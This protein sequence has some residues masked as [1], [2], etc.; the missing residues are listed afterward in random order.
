MRFVVVGLF[1]L[2]V[3][4]CDSRKAGDSGSVNLEAYTSKE[5]K[6]QSREQ[7][8][9]YAETEGHIRPAEDIVKAHGERVR[10][11]WAPSVEKTSALT[12]LQAAIGATRPQIATL[13]T[14]GVSEWEALKPGIEAGLKEIDARKEAYEKIE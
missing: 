3:V 14:A 6:P 8:R 10:A 13:K 2:A 4:G 7:I 11:G 1:A 12:A 5:S 9:F